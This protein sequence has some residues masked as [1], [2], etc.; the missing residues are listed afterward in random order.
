MRSSTSASLSA[1]SS[2]SRADWSR[3]IAWP[4]F[5][6]I[7]GGFTQKIHAVAPRFSAPRRSAR[8]PRLVTPRQGAPPIVAQPTGEGAL[9]MSARHAAPQRRRQVI[10]AFIVLLL[11]TGGW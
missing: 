9:L 7:L 4:F 5:F 10:A 8:S 11:A 2:S 3:A 1:S 6:V